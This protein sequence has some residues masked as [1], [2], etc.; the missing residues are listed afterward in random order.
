MKILQVH[1]RYSVPGGEEIVVDSERA[2]LQS[3]GHEVVRYERSNEGLNSLR[4]QLTT[5]WHLT[6]SQRSY[7]EILDVIK[8]ELPDL[9]HVHNFFPT[10]TPA[11]FFAA[12]AAGL[13]VV[14]TLHN[15]R[16]LCPS[17][18]LFIQGKVDE[19]ALTRGPYFAALKRPYRN[20][21]VGSLAVARM[22]AAHNSRG[23]WHTVVD[24]FIAMTEFA[25]QTFARAGFPRERL[26]VKPHFVADPLVTSRQRSGALF[27]GR[28]SAAKGFPVLMEAWRNLDTPLTI[29]GEDI[30]GL[31]CAMNNRSIKFCG[32]QPPSKVLDL[33]ASSEVL[34]FPSMAYESFGLVLIEALACGLPIV[35]SDIAGVSEIV[36]DGLTG[37]LVPPGDAQALAA[38]VTDVVGEKGRKMRD[39]ARAAYAQRF[40]PP[41][42]YE[43]TMAIY[44]EALGQQGE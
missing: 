15:F 43:M 36:D 2:L 34:V 16:L 6:F 7:S 8:H 23:T 13:P 42:A 31:A 37:R 29:V 3:Q 14:H 33:M 38:A 22:I 32:P 44:R 30:D 4:R 40:S 27:V 9:V 5:A 20:S 39:L 18:S 21:L 35:A 11:V 19:T 12:K 1:N 17:G 28:L 25:R 10:I 41:R 26:A 24:R